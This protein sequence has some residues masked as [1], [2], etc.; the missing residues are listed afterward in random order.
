MLGAMGVKQPYFLYVGGFE[1]WKNVTVLVKAFARFGRRD[2]T[3]V[4][5]GALDGHAAA[6]RA[7]AAKCGVEQQVRFVGYQ[8]DSGLVAL[9]SGAMA[10]VHPSLYE[11]FG[12]PLVEAM[13]CRTPVTASGRGAMREVLGNAALYFDPT[14]PSS[15]AAALSALADDPHMRTR[16]AQVG[17]ERAG[18]FSWEKTAK[19]TLDVYET[20]AQ[21]KVRR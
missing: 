5:A 16:L 11:S 6:L 9:Y 4:L 19:A 12:F 17:M 21:Q 2:Y 8:A 3:L 20:V 18:G 1:P 10:L 13:S 7:L 15:V 14:D